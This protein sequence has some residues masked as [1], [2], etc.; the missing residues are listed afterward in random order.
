MTAA[1]VTEAIPKTAM[2]V[3]IAIEPRAYSQTIGYTVRAL[4]PR[5][6]VE[7]LD[8]DSLGSEVE[9]RAFD[10]VLCSLPRPVALAEGLT[11]VEFRPYARPKEQLLVN[12]RYLGL[13]SVEF[14]DL[15]F[16]LDEAESLRRCA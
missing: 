3:L 8:P 7:V 5:Y 4:R 9:R 15:L 10:L 6:A 13:E 11:W 2:R 12:D 14:A 1:S 16:I